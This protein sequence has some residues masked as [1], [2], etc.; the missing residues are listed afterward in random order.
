MSQ[1]K[2]SRETG[3]AQAT[4][5]N[6]EN[7]K[8]TP[9]YLTRQRLANTLGFSVEEIF[10]NDGSLVKKGRGKSSASKSNSIGEILISNSQQSLS[11]NPIKTELS[12]DD[13]HLVKDT[14]VIGFIFSNDGIRLKFF[15]IRLFKEDEFQEGT[16]TDAIGKFSFDNLKN[17][18][19]TLTT[20]EKS[21]QIKIKS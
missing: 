6:I 4:I 5:S 15:P 9:S 2:L 1:I 11:I 16:Y 8:R 19:Y 21:I 7:D 14:K 17:G 12:K 3:V 10:P 13:P 20:D 18:E